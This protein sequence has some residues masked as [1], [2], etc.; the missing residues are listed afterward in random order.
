MGSRL[1]SYVLFFLIAGVSLGAGKSDGQGGLCPGHL[2][3]EQLKAE[4][5]DKSQ[6]PLVY[7]SVLELYGPHYQLRKMHSRVQPRGKVTIFD[8][9]GGTG[10]VATHVMRDDPKRTVEIFDDSKVMTDVALTK[11]FDPKKIH[12]FDIKKFIRNDG[13]LVPDGSVDGIIANHVIYLLPLEEIEQCFDEARR[14]LR[15]GGVLSIASVRTLELEAMLRFLQTAKAA[16]LRKEALGLI[17]VGSTEIAYSTN[18]RLTNRPPST[19]LNEEIIALGKARGFKPI[20]GEN[21]VIYDG[22]AFFVA[23]TKE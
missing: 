14:V 1:L 11:G 22:A 9:G 6:Y 18:L 7:D 23:F 5:S 10:I 20:E 8:A 21:H 15:V 19:F 3:E 16:S 17:P 4:F 2:R 13:I 12:T